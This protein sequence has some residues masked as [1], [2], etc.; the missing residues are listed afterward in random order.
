MIDPI[1]LALAGCGLAICGLFL[2]AV[3]GRKLAKLRVH[4]RE[5][6]RQLE[7]VHQAQMAYA[8]ATEGALSHL[9]DGLESLTTVSANLEMKTYSLELQAQAARSVAAAGQR[10]KVSAQQVAS[11]PSRPL[12]RAEQELLAAVSARN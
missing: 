9:R 1:V 4:Q 6:L 10:A 7:A 8:E 3:L 2:S 5:L 11:V 12:N